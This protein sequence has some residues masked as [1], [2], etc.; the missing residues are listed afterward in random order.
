MISLRTSQDQLA[1]K[2]PAPTQVHKSFLLHVFIVFELY[3]QIH[4]VLIYYTMLQN[5]AYLK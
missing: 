3:C 5:D 4:C 2:Y 1:R